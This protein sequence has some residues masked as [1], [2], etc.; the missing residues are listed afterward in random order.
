MYMLITMLVRHRMDLAVNKLLVQKSVDFKDIFS[1]Y[2][3]I[4]YLPVQRLRALRLMRARVPSMTTGL[5]IYTK[6]SQ[7]LWPYTYR[8]FHNK[9]LLCHRT[10]KYYGRWKKRYHLFIQAR[11]DIL[12]LLNAS[13]SSVVTHLQDVP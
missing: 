11:Y 12:T 5:D 4:Y 9:L 6:A 1:I 2:S 13:H 3:R 8:R 10:L 7:I